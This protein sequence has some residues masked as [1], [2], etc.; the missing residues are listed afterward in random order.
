[1]TTHCTISRPKPG[2]AHMLYGA[3]DR[4]EERA[5]YNRKRVT[6]KLFSSGN[7][8]GAIICGA[9]LVACQVAIAAMSGWQEAQQ[10]VLDPQPRERRA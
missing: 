8:A 1:M 5:R 2:P 7:F 9:W 3:R 4:S 6:G 10:A